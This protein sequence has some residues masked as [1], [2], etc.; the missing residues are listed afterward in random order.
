MSRVVLIAPFLGWFK[1]EPTNGCG[2]KNRYQNGT[3][4]SGN[5]DQNPH[6]P[7]CL[8]LSHSQ[9]PKARKPTWDLQFMSHGHTHASL[10]EIDSTSASH[11][12]C[13]PGPGPCKLCESRPMFDE[14]DSLTNTLGQKETNSVELVSTI[15][16]QARKPMK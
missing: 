8:I 5:M 6:N 10:G 3:L 2:S 11:N 13:S 9:I 4:V 1:L 12:S 15:F 16:N 14:Q 7:S